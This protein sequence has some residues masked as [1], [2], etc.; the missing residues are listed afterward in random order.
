MGQLS[1]IVGLHDA[2]SNTGKPWDVNNCYS[3]SC[4]LPAKL[5]LLSRYQKIWEMQFEWA[6]ELTPEASKSFTSNHKMFVSP[7]LCGQS[8]W[9][10][11]G[12]VF[13]DSLSMFQAVVAEDR[14][15]FMT[16]ASDLARFFV[17]L[18]FGSGV[19]LCS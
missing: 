8:S 18:Q 3:I 14:I 5:G 9:K 10:L 7:R 11:G 4:C 13:L 17:T 15:E 16:S 2:V 1:K 6:K 12:K 19:I